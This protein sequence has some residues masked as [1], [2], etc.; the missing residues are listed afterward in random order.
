M[1]SSGQALC[2]GRRRP[3]SSGSSSSSSQYALCALGVGLVGLGVVMI[4]WTVVP[5]EQRL[6]N[7]T[8]PNETGAETKQKTSSVAFVLVGGGLAMLLL[9]VCLGLKNKMKRRGQ[10]TTPAAGGQY[11]DRVPVEPGESETPAP[12]YD[13][14]S[15]DEAVGSGRYPIRQSNLRN[16]TSQLP[17]Y[18][19]LIAAVENDGEA[20]GTAN[21]QNATSAP[22]ANANP[23]PTRSGSRAS[24]ILRPLRVRRIKSEK[25]HAKD[26]RLNI[27]SPPQGARVTIEPLTPPPQYENKAPEFPTEPV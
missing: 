24:R 26:I 5:L 15:Y 17:S 21:G 10:E 18:E 20:S 6:N 19:D 9:A 3:N 13:V 1:C 27:Q 4:L 8:A 16:S 2:S 11:T 23:Q 12:N 22:A 7:T 25:L 14:P